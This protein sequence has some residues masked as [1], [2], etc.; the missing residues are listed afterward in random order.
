M[1]SEINKKIKNP[2]VQLRLA[3][4]FQM[5]FD[6]SRHIIQYD[7]ISPL[8]HRIEARSSDFDKVLQ[9]KNLKGEGF[10]IFTEK[11]CK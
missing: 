5:I 4:Y 6:L 8:I 1:T 9:I 7:H 3:A 11:K 10:Q 2:I